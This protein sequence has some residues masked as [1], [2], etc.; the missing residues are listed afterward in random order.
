[1]RV[2]PILNSDSYKQFHP[3]MYVDGMGLL[4]SNM[5]PRSFKRLGNQKN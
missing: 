5:T 1:M 2:L 3:Q 4:C